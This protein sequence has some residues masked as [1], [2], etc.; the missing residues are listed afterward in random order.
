LYIFRPE[1]NNHQLQNLPM[2][3]LLVCPLLLLFFRDHHLH[4]HLLFI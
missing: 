2:L 3:H 1:P 4:W